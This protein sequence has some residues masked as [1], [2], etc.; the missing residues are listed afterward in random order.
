LITNAVE[1]PLAKQL[2]AGDILPNSTVTLGVEAG[3][4]TFSS[5]V[6]PADEA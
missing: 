3:Q 1:T 4:L 2:I 6:N 5:A